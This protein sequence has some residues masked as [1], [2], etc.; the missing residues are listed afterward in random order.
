MKKCLFIF[1]PISGKN[2]KLMKKMDYIEK[3]LKEKYDVVDIVP[4]SYAGHAIEL[5]KNACGKYDSLLFSGGDGTFSEV[6]KGIGESKEAP[7]LGFIP[8]GTVSDMANNYNIPRNIKKAIDVCVEGNKTKIDVCKINDSY[9]AY[10][11]GLGTYTSSTFNATPKLKKKYG[12]MAYFLQ[13]AKDMFKTS[14]NKL[15]FTVGK[16]R[17]TEDSLLMLI[18]NTKSVGGFSKLNYKNKLGDGKFDVVVVKKPQLKTPVNI[19]RLFVQGV[20]N[21]YDNDNFTVFSTDE[22]T[23]DVP[24]TVK[25]NLDGDPYEAQKINIQCLKK[26]LSLFVPKE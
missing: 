17:F 20:H 25:W 7:A 4:T 18:M 6:V 19:W 15:S 23:I 16:K 10:V 14:E 2:K 1:N 3:R 5:A 11:C 21:F 22:V 12:R 24:N 9:F 13:G 26:R 8:S